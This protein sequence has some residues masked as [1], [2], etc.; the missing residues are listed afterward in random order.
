M[1][2]ISI[3]SLPIV[4]I[5]TAF[6]I[7][8]CNVS[9]AEVT[10][11]LQGKITPN[12]SLQISSFKNLEER[13]I[14]KDIAIGLQKEINLH[15]DYPEDKYYFF[16]INNKKCEALIDATSKNTIIF[17]FDKNEWV[18]LKNG[19]QADP[20][21]FSDLEPFNNYNNIN[22]KDSATFVNYHLEFMNRLNL[23][24]LS[25]GKELTDIQIYARRKG[26]GI[27]CNTVFGKKLFSVT[28][29]F[30]DGINTAIKDWAD[31]EN[32]QLEQ[33]SY[34]DLLAIRDFHMFFSHEIFPYDQG[35]LTFYDMVNY[36]EKWLHKMDY[37]SE[38]KNYIIG[39]VIQFYSKFN[40]KVD[41]QFFDKL[42]K[43]CNEN[44]AS[45]HADFIKELSVRYVTNFA[46]TAKFNIDA[47]NTNGQ[48]LDISQIKEKFIFI[49]FWSTWCT[50]CIKEEPF[51]E[52]LR[53]EYKDKVAFIKISIDED[54]G[55]W[56]AYLSKN[57]S[58]ELSYILPQ[59]EERENTISTFNLKAIPKY[60][61]IN[62]EGTIINF[63]AARPS[64]PKLQ[65]VLNELIQ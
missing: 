45:H 11:I 1:K 24:P 36:T 6:T 38:V 52:Q 26:F 44:Q 40:M 13:V 55:K 15:L 25:E 34:Y 64:D 29:N 37:S 7:S 39:D 54:Y 46:G 53:S 58:S 51:I 56:K 22:A 17:D 2:N 42:N 31:L 5:L 61:I 63:T 18:A 20:L 57:N 33:A 30:N 27:F 65:D 19:S 3:K 32:L 23:F 41:Q 62:N 12:S 47:T 60:I 35:P 10:I 59:N 8:I 16:A 48:Q 50:P 14:H 9:A 49:D 28:R 43:F 21:M 4:F